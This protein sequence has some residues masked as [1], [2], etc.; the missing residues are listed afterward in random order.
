MKSRIVRL[1]GTLSVHR[2]LEHPASN[3]HL[4]PLEGG[5]YNYNSREAG[6]CCWQGSSD[7]A[8]G[9]RAHCA[10]FSGRSFAVLRISEVQIWVCRRELLSELQMV[11]PPEL[12]EFRM[13]FPPELQEFRMMFPPELQEFRMMFPPEL[14]MGSL[15]ETCRF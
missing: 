7:G 5:G 10:G 15:S 3:D 12:Q 1:P 8:A 4:L 13:M 6:S 9:R 14:Q 11:F 2:F